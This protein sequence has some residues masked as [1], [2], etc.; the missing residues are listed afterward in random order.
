MFSLNYASGEL[1]LHR[2]LSDMSIT[3]YYI[4]IRTTPTP[5]ID[6]SRLDDAYDKSD[7]QVLR[8]HVQIR[9]GTEEGD[10][11]YDKYNSVDFHS[12]YQ[13]NIIRAGRAGLFVGRH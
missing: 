9:N 10:D 7:R 8:V 5:N 1:R 2:A 11:P 13:R 12:G 6:F 4:C 3:N